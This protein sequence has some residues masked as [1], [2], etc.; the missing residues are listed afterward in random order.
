MID[1]CDDTWRDLLGDP[2]NTSGFSSNEEGGT[3]VV[4]HENFSHGYHKDG[5]P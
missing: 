4:Q 1:T 5:R 3:T 2:R